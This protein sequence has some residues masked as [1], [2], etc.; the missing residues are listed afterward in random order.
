MGL[1]DTVV[2]AF[3]SRGRMS[4]SCSEASG[5]TLSVAQLPVV[6]RRHVQNTA[7]C[8]SEVVLFTHPSEGECRKVAC[9]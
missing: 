6:Q 8:C 1:L 9:L 3:H 7:T 5:F 2:S 4:W